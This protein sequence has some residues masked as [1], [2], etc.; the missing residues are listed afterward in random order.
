MLLKP[1][2][3]IIL[4]EDFFVSSLKDF[5]KTLY[6]QFIIDLIRSSF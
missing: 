3:S 1:K 4:I 6:N 5:F 2:E